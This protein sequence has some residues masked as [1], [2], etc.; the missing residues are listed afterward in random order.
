VSTPNDSQIQK[1]P[2]SLK[3][4]YES[5]D[6]WFRFS[7]IDSIECGQQGLR[8]AF[9]AGWCARP[10]ASCPSCGQGAQEAGFQL[11][12]RS[13]N[14]C[15]SEGQWSVARA[16]LRLEMDHSPAR[17]FLRSRASGKTMLFK[18]LEEYFNAR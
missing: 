9:M 5:F 14:V 1:E 16:V 10:L 18:L 7:C 8:A 2:S 17:R 15:L 11:F 12:L 4:I 3:H 13:K 6:E